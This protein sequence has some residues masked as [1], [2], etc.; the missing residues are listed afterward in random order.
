MSRFPIFEKQVPRIGRERDFQRICDNLLKRTPQHVS[1]VAPR[2]FGK[3][4]LLAAVAEKMRSSSDFECVIEWDLG[5]NTPQT[6]EEF[7]AEMC[8]WIAEGFRASGKDDA[9]YLTGNGATFEDLKEFIDL[10]GGEQRR[11]LMLWD[12]FDRPLREGQF[13]RNLWDNLRELA[14]QSSLVL[15]TASRQR[16]GDLIRDG[17]SVTS[18]FWQ[19][20]EVMRLKAL[21]EK[22][23]QVFIDHASDLKFS[24]GGLTELVNWTGGIPPLVASVLNG[25]PAGPV[26]NE[27]INRAAGGSDEQRE[28]TIRTLLDDLTAPGKELLQA[29]SERGKLPVSETPFEERNDLLENGLIKSEGEKLAASCRLVARSLD[30]QGSNISL[31]SRLFGD[32]DAYRENI[33]SL[34]EL[35]LGQVNCFDDR[36]FKLVGRSLEALPEDP[37]LCLSDLTHVV[38][39]ALQ[40][41]WRRE[42]GDEPR[43]SQDCITSWTENSGALPRPILE[44]MNRDDWTI[45]ADPSKQLPILQLLTGSHYAFT[46]SKARFVGK[47]TY[48]LLN[49]LHSFRNRNQHA[50]GQSMH[51]GVAASAL[52]LCVELLACLDRESI[53]RHEPIGGDAG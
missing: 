13:S 4:V 41:I 15:V 19:I 46:E 6:D 27:S 45:P 14:M 42:F 3:S 11:I 47:D 21:D 24:R 1:L 53:D 22:D 23:I 25:L 7:I 9:D 44:M 40:V 12:G 43:I 50:G 34:L 30:Q 10:L 39:Q 49:A 16:L 37:D 35:R 29:L 26:D 31:Q 8:K 51:E 38:Q 18:E 5:H 33:R 17:D 20:F 32:W 48:V 36:L 28:D 2:F 52:L